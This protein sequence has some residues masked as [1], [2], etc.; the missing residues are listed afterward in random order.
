MGH[1]E[2]SANQIQNLL[3]S[4]SLNYSISWIY[5]YGLDAASTNA[6]YG[7]KLVSADGFVPASLSGRISFVFNADADLAA[8]VGTQSLSAANLYFLSLLP[9]STSNLTYFWHWSFS[10]IVL[11]D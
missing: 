11:L 1:Y 10:D 4:T 2:D 8:A 9:P 3:S 6:L 5:G 7:G